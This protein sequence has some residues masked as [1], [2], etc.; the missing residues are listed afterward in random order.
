MDEAI[1]PICTEKIEISQKVKFL[2]RISCPTCEALLEVVNLDP[3]E[4][5]WIFYDYLDESNGRDQSKSNK[6]AK[7][8]LCKENVHLGSQLKVG[9]QVICPG[10][11]AQLEIVSLYPAELDWPYDGYDYYYQ[12]DDFFEEEF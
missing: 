9:D 5:D 2:E 11:D 6:N 7:C 8:P 4:L 10:C 3:L 1:C 12:D